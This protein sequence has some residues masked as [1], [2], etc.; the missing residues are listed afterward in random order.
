MAGTWAQSVRGN[1]GVAAPH[2]ARAAVVAVGVSG[3]TAAGLL[4]LNAYAAGR[5]VAVWPV[6]V[7]AL[8]AF[9]VLAAQVATQRLALIQCSR[10]LERRTREV[11]EARTAATAAVETRDEFL[12]VA[13]HELK[14]P[15]T[16]LRGFAQLLLRQMERGRPLDAERLQ[17]SLQV[18]D[19]QSEKLTHLVEQ[20]LDVSRIQAGRLVLEPGPTDLGRLVREVVTAQQ[21]VT[22]RHQLAVQAPA[23]LP[24][25]VDALRLEQVLTNLIENA[26]RYS[27]QGGMIDVQLTAL[28]QDGASGV[29]RSVQLLVR[30]HGIGV[31]AEH[32]PHIFDRFYQAHPDSWL[33]GMGLGLY[34][35]RQIVDLH[36]GTVT[37]EFPADGGS[38]FV[39]LLP[40]NAH[41]WEA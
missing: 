12:T 31:P 17:A 7:L 18:I 30:D 36:G 40:L 21:S 11:Q 29:P 4:L 13:A 5:P 2:V 19:H 37:A 6:G 22:T 39:V 9:T 34:I 24:A 20:L 32:R 27:P 14:T 1:G 15:V 8:V 28:A 35:T 3:T 10:D 26:L 16:S 41:R 23:S 33:G 25:T 38:R